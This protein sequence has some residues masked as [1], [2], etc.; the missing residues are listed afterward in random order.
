MKA[1][2]EGVVENG[3]G[4]KLK[5]AY[6]KIAG[7][8]GTS[9]LDKSR[10]AG[11]GMK[12]QAS[13]VGYFPADDPIYS[14]IVVIAAP[15]KSIYGSK[16]SGTVFSAIANKVYSTH[17]K[18]HKSINEVHK[19][20]TKSPISQ[21]GSR[22]DIETLLPIL[23]VKWSRK[24][25]EKWVQT[26]AKDDRIVL[27]GKNMSKKV[28]PN[29]SG[30]GLKDALYILGNMGYYVDIEGAGVVVSQSIAPGTEVVKGSHIKLVLE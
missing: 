30:M 28:I 12:Y 24:T 21:G 16:V 8:T 4:R 7:K 13:F 19:K 6:F 5:S 15:N 10:S 18:Y 11:K 23:D 17:L 9:Q 1:C 25:D 22:K 27:M 2:M 3:T 20:T 29:L 26:T 14:C